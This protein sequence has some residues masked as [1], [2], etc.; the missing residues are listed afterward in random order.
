MQGNRV[1][2]LLGELSYR[3]SHSL[4]FGDLESRGYKLTY[5]RFD[6]SDLAL[7]KYGEWLYDH[8]VLFAPK[9]DNFGGRVDSGQIIDFLDAG[10][11]LIVAADYGL[12]DA[13]RLIG[14]EC[15]VFFDTSDTKVLDHLNYDARDVDGDHSVII[16]DN[17]NKAATVIFGHE[18]NYAP[19]LFDGV[20]HDIDD[21]QNPLLHRLLT[22][23]GSAY[24]TNPKTQA[25]DVVRL[26]GSRTTLVS[27]LQA[28]NNARAIFT[29][30]LK[31]FSNDFFTSSVR[32]ANEG[33]NAKPVKSGNRELARD[34]VT[35]AFKERG[36]IRS[37]DVRHHRVGE[38]S[39]PAM[40]RIKDRVSYSVRLEEWD[41]KNWVPFKAD[42]V[43]LE[44]VRLDP[45]IR[46]NLKHDGKGRFSTEFAV[47]DVHGVYTFRLD[48]Q[49]LGYTNILEKHTVAV[50][51]FRHDEYERFITA[52]YPYYTGAFSM[53]AGVFI[54]SIFFMYNREP[55]SK[56]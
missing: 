48:Y 25:A 6:D 20:G 32:R 39:A 16:A 5:L 29:G 10:G 9:A 15:G 34:I 40:Y 49:R 46:V 33:E 30:S 14:R 45:Y 18:P 55:T 38:S 28:R 50:R 37:S 3:D 42:D 26:A 4:F 19:I 27:A 44:F 52:A 54:F 56:K 1:L 36:V 23:S 2:V 13:V 31:L 51:P 53:L 8:I 43:Q 24:S 22:A 7:S 11:N 35:W 47:P 41:G 17:F 12:G 21:V